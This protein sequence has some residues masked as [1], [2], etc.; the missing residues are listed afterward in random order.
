MPVVCVLLP[1]LELRRLR[2]EGVSSPLGL[3]FWGP[4]GGQNP[5]R[6]VRFGFWRD[7][8]SSPLLL[9]RNL[10]LVPESV[11]FVVVAFGGQA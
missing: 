3:W 6:V 11:V 9:G 2:R 1:R 5:I 4:S 7:G 10:L 8:L